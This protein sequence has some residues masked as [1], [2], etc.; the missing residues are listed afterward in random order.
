MDAES[1]ETSS[2][3]LF[4]MVL[5]L[6]PIRLARTKAGKRKLRLFGVGCARLFWDAIPDDRLKHGV[7]LAERVADGLE[8]RQALE[9]VHSDLRYS[10]AAGRI[11]EPEEWHWVVAKLAIGCC[12]VKAN[13]VALNSIGFESM[14]IPADRRRV[15]TFRSD[16]LRCIFGNPFQKPAFSKKWRS[17]T[18]T[19][20][21]TGIYEEHAFDRLPI[22]ADA[23]EEAGCDEPTMLSHLRGPG[24]HCR[25]CWVLDLALG[26]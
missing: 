17:E 22:L 23:L 9:E 6:S 24:P 21:A 7:E 15:L 2:G 12:D 26:K 20:L 16:L 13:D 10:H 11:R 3:D 19:A 25:G 4:R 14:P 1:W 8:S 5:A 18:V